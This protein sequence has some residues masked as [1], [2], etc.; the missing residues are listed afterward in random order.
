MVSLLLVHSNS[1]PNF[2]MADAQ[3]ALLQLL[4]LADSAL[5][6][7]AQAHSFGLETLVAEGLL[8]VD[9]LEDFLHDY[10]TELGAVDGYFC[11]Q[12]YRLAEATES[13]T[14]IAQ[15]V[16][17]NQRLSA[18]RP[19][20]ETRAASSALGRRFLAL[21][22]S[23]Y[24]NT[25]LPSTLQTVRQAGSELHHATLF[26]LVGGLLQLDEEATV[27][28]YLQQSSTGLLAA[29]QKLM[30]IGQSQ[31]VSI[32]WQLKPT[33][34]NAARASHSLDAASTPTSFSF[35]TEIGSMRHAGLPVRLFIS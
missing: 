28:A 31:V 14:F 2:P 17:I 6:I 32:L 21:A 16:R 8:T 20:R 33:M 12:A 15:W 26:G 23:L 29:M 35:L 11:R 30:P 25:N 13:Q 9:G 24:T 27:A 4:Q 5:P 3:L 7:G 1:Q 34:L 22:L 10:V 19:A 18:L